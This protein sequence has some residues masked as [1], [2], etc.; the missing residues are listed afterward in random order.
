MDH[1]MVLRKAARPSLTLME[2]VLEPK[3]ADVFPAVSVS[4]VLNV[5]W[6]AV[7]IGLLEQVEAA[8]PLDGDLASSRQRC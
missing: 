8:A 4:L 1:A 5:Q 7:R 3:A 6:E 2:E